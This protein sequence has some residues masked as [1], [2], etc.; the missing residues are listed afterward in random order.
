MWCTM[1][2]VFSVEQ[3]DLLF[4]NSRD[5]VFFMEKIENDYRYVHLNEAAIKL[6]D[7]NPTGKFIS[8]V[9]PSHISKNIFYYYDLTLEKQEQPECS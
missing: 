6:I 8:Q 5:A 1:K 7:M 3:F 4:A 9:I 2:A